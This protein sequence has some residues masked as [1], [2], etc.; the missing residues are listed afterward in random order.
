MYFSY[1]TKGISQF[2]VVS[3]SHS[4]SQIRCNCLLCSCATK[5]PL[6]GRK[7]HYHPVVVAQA[8]PVPFNPPYESQAFGQAVTLCAT[9]VSAR[10]GWFCVEILIF[11]CRD[12]LE[13]NASYPCCLKA[14]QIGRISAITAV[15]YVYQAPGQR[16]RP[17]PLP[18]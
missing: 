17:M 1:P 6:F 12:T 5:P 3:R 4:R 10:T 8:L 16:D 9:D 11:G 2:S 13:G 15:P 14:A 7:S 18:V